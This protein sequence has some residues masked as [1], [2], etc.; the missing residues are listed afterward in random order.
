MVRIGALLLSAF[1]LLMGSTVGISKRA[2][3]EPSRP[4]SETEIAAQES[5]IKITIASIGRMSGLPSTRY[6]V[7]E[8]IPITITMTNTSGQPISVCVSD[9]LYQDLPTL[10]KDG[11]RLPLSTWQ[12]TDLRNARQD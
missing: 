8:Q 7:G 4:L 2:G 3:F 9:E 10:T 5:N 1:I 6:R 12:A 11:K